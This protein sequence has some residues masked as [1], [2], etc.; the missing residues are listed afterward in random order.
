LRRGLPKTLAKHYQKLKTM[1][2]T[3]GAQATIWYILTHI[4]KDGATFTQI[5]NAYEIIVGETV[6]NGTIGNILGRMRR[7]RIIIE[8]HP[9]STPAM[10]RTSTFCSAESTRLELGFKPIG[11]GRVSVCRKKCSMKIQG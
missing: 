8:K 9:G 10:L 4:F 5:K 7:K 2:R 6:S 1:Y 3:Y 11:L